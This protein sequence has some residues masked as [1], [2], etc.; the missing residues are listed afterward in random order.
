LIFTYDLWSAKVMFLYLTIFLP[1]RLSDI[2]VILKSH[3]MGQAI[4]ETQSLSKHY[5][6]IKA[7]DD[8]NIKVFPGEVHGILG[9]NGSGKTTTLGIL[10]G[11]IQPK[12][13]SFSWFGSQT[14]AAARRRIGST[15]ENPL[16]Y[17]Y[18]NAVDNLKMIADIR[19]CTYAF[20]PEALTHVGLY[21][22]KNSRFKSY[23]MGMKQRLAIASALLGDPEVL[24]FDEPT[25][26][27]D[28]QGI[29]EI[30]ALVRSI[31][32][33]G[34]TIL[35]ASHLLDEVQKLCTHVTV[36]N[37]GRCLFSGTVGEFVHSADVAE[38]STNDNIKL[39]AVLAGW[40]GCLSVD[41][42]SGRLRVELKTGF[43]TASL[44]EFAFTNGF[45]LN[46][47]T[48]NQNSLEQ[49]FLDL[50]KHNA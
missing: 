45:I 26:G 30:R 16:F 40:E 39:K 19:G 29:A 2:N 33:K 31:A 23:S 34:K 49:N 28:P 38:I 9:P 27:L 3:Y 10:L 46:H 6:R 21:E 25:N 41:E 7:V 1:A 13:G 20:I 44:N 24:I 18:M 4:L 47:L 43:N 50:L 12:S 42:Q 35:M 17:P 8:L 5:G 15:L 48:L 36:L 11:A 14:D 22:R 32:A 37:H